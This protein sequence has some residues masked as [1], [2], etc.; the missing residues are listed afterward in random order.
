MGRGSGRDQDGLALPF[1]TQGLHAHAWSSGP[2][3]NRTVF[4]SLDLGWKLLRI[5]PKEML[6]RIPQSMTDEF[7]SRQGAQ[8]DPASDTAL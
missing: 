1:W 4:E 2:Y 8:Q 7:Y 5:F 6:K 3:E